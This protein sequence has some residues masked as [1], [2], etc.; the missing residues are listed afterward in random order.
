[1]MYL[2][3]EKNIRFLM[4]SLAV[5]LGPVSQN[6]LL[7]LCGDI[8]TCFQ[9]AE[10]DLF[11]AAR[12]YSWHGQHLGSARIRAFVD[13][14]ESPQLKQKAEQTAEHAERAG[15]QILT[16]AD[17]EYPR[18]FE[19]LPD[20]PVVLYLKGKLC[21]NRYQQS[22]GIIGARRCSGEGKQQA[23]VAAA[24]AVRNHAAIISGMAKGID[25]YAHTAAVKEKGYT[26]AVLGNG[27]DICYPKE[28]QALYEAII[29]TGCILSEYPPGTEP[30]NYSFPRRNRLIAALSD[31]LY[32]IEAG[33]NSGTQS[34]VAGCEK[35]GKPVVS[36][37]D[38]NLTDLSGIDKMR[39]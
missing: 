34:T 5:G 29:D 32:V 18:R 15:V 31:R 22:V 10:E 28:H 37:I 19:D 26:I 14:R 16:N 23:I 11:G 27:P 25:S 35:Y 33:R 8:E 17:E 1:M 3:E 30:R 39:T 9:T 38:L 13:Q 2:K 21:I 4:L 12:A 7:R 6:L 20:M 36:G 24:D